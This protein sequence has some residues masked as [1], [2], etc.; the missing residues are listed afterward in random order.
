M[1]WTSP[2]LGLR[3]QICATSSDFLLAER[4]AAE[5]AIGVPIIGFEK[6]GMHYK[7][8]LSRRGAFLLR[9]LALDWQ[10]SS[11]CRRRA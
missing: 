3:R 2:L 8:Q 6:V 1:P 5:A 11:T 9:V 4:A 7:Q 10:E